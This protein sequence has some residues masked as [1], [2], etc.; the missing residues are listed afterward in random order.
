MIRAA[1]SPAFTLTPDPTVDYIPAIWVLVLAVR[2]EKRWAVEE[3]KRG[4]KYVHYIS[5]WQERY[6]SKM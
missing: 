6:L 2:V 3:K 1:A 4:R 5:K